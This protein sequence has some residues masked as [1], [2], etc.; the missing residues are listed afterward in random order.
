MRSFTSIF[1]V[2]SPALAMALAMALALT[3]LAESTAVG[4][5]PLRSLQPAIDRS[6]VVTKGVAAVARSQKKK[7]RPGHKKSKAKSTTDKT[8]TA[9]NKKPRHSHKKSKANSTPMDITPKPKSIPMDKTSKPR[10]VSLRLKSQTSPCITYKEPI[11]CLPPNYGSW[12]WETSVGARS[13]PRAVPRLLALSLLPHFL[14]SRLA[15]IAALGLT[16]FY[17]C[18]SFVTSS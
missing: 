3:I 14:L 8:S 17:L 7:S 1:A 9:Q 5:R 18:S 16:C 6:R 11:L 12:S 2:L 15:S 10:K 4:T 13:L